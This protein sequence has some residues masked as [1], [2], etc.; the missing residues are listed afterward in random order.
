[1]LKLWRR[2]HELNALN[3]QAYV[4]LRS[5]ITRND[6]VEVFINTTNT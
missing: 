3:V 4:C 5:Q 1:M 6:G 2:G